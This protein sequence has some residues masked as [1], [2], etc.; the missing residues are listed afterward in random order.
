MIDC[1]V[2]AGNSGKRGAD[3]HIPMKSWTFGPRTAR[4][5]GRTSSGISLNLWPRKITR[6]PP[7][8]A[9]VGSWKTGIPGSAKCRPKRISDGEIRGP[10]KAAAL[11]DHPHSVRG[12]ETQASRSKNT[13]LEIFGVRVAKSTRSRFF[14][15][16]IRRSSDAKR[17]CL[18]EARLAENVASKSQEIVKKMSR[19]RKSGTG[20]L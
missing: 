8:R 13:R 10:R 18:A 15:V 3:R 4:P 7:A 19:G 2:V 5:S 12:R 9:A 17:N 14:A 6:T 16:N 11:E 20:D 1:N